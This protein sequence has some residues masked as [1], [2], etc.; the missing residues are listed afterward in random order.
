MVD[1]SMLADAAKPTPK[2]TMERLRRAVVVLTLGM[3]LGPPAHAQT[4]AQGFELPEGKSGMARVVV[5]EK[6]MG[7]IK[8]S[9]H[10]IY[11]VHNIV[12]YLGP[13]MRLGEVGTGIIPEEMKEI[14]ESEARNMLLNGF[15]ITERRYTTGFTQFVLMPP[16]RIAVTNENIVQV[17]NIFKKYLDDKRG[18][19]TFNSSEKIIKEDALNEIKA[20]AVVQ[21]TERAIV[22]KTDLNRMPSIK[23]TPFDQ[24]RKQNI[25]FNISSKWLILDPKRKLTINE[26]QKMAEKAGVTKED[27]AKLIPILQRAIYDN[28]VVYSLHVRLSERNP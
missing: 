28:R 6:N 19:V 12:F 13:P 15:L 10:D 7:D 5:N 1:F 8:T 21:I 9:F 4:Q 23:N 26:L 17:T 27:L 24:K 25:W 16:I 20:G 3:S 18:E 14:R 2:K 11:N 22:A